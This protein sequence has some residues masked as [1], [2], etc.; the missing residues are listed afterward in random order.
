MNIYL[1]FLT[2]LQNKR[3]FFVLFLTFLTSGSISDLLIIIDNKLQTHTH[4][5]E[6]SK[7]ANSW[8]NEGC[9]SHRK[10]R[11]YI[12]GSGLL[13]KKEKPRCDSTRRANQTQAKNSKLPLAK[14]THTLRNLGA[15]DDGHWWKTH[16]M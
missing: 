15:S 8:W 7:A 2:P 3:L 6:D 4:L 16:Q 10:R 11:G 5:E 1:L 12:E 9:G 13:Y 14:T